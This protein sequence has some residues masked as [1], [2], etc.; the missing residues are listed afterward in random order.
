MVP[1][2]GPERTEDGLLPK[3]GGWCVLDALEAVRR[4]CEGMGM[5]PRLEGAKPMF[6]QLGVGYQRAGAARAR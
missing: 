6:E 4:R 5:W 2:G 3:D 1:E